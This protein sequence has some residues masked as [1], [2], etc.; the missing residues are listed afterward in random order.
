VQRGLL[1]AG[2]AL[3]HVNRSCL[4]NVLRGCTVCRSYTC[5]APRR[6]QSGA[7][8]QKRPL[9]TNCSLHPWTVNSTNNCG[10]KQ[11]ESLHP[12]AAGGHILRPAGSLPPQAVAVLSNS[13]SGSLPPE[14]PVRAALALIDWQ[15]WP[16]L[17]GSPG[18]YCM[19][20][21]A[22]IAWQPWPLFAWQ[23]L[24]FIAWQ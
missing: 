24:A 18:L 23:P 3:F 11:Q 7:A 13:S 10:H 22:F 6:R 9:H 5:C 8:G 19:A 16:S 1:S 21:L 12:Q 2:P 20:S 4:L 17:P 14:V 15:P